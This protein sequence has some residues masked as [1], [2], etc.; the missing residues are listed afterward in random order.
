MKVTRKELR[1]IIREA[2]LGEMHHH[3]K[4]DV[5]GETRAERERREAGYQSGA[6]PAYKTP[7]G[8][9]LE[10]DWSPDVQELE[11]Y[12]KSPQ[13]KEL[14][15]SNIYNLL[16]GGV[17]QKAK[18]I[19]S[20]GFASASAEFYEQMNSA[21]NQ[22]LERLGRELPGDY[23]PHTG[24]RGKKPPQPQRR[25]GSAFEDPTTNWFP[26]EERRRRKK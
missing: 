10:G 23:T 19:D 22:A 24:Q 8:Q 2:M 17:Q 3:L 12:Y 4:H 11:S 13:F 9:T 14:L 15:T 25:S 20:M 6:L 16:K 26:L 1:Q 18:D 5:P 21:S 7:P